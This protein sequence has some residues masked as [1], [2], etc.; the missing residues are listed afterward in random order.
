MRFF[1]CVFP[2]DGGALIVDE[3][4]MI[5]IILMNSLLKVS[6]IAANLNVILQEAIN[7]E[8]SRSVKEDSNTARATV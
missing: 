4:S 3:C 5:D 7:P 2:L 8:K 1:N 6:P